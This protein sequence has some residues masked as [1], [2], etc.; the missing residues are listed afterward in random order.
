[1]A[2]HVRVFEMFRGG[3]GKPCPYKGA[4]YTNKVFLLMQIVRLAEW[5]SRCLNWPLFA[6]RALSDAAQQWQLAHA[7]PRPPLEWGGL[8]GQTLQAFQYVGVVEIEGFRVEVFPKLDA[9]LLGGAP[10]DAELADST[11]R[12]LLPMLEAANFGGWVEVGRAQ[13][14]EA[15]LAFSDVWAYLLGKHLAPELRQGLVRAYRHECDDLLGVRGK[16]A[17]SRQV[18]AL[19]GRMDKVACEWDEFS[20]DTP[21]NRL[22]KCACRV[23]IGRTSHPVARGALSDCL[24][25]LDEV[26]DVRVGVALRECER[27]IWPRAALR[28]EAAFRLAELLLREL[29]PDLDGASGQSWSFL[30][31]M[32]AVFEGFC[33][34]ALEAR[35][36]CAVETQ[37][38]LPTLL[39]R[40]NTMPQLADFVWTRG[41]RWIG[42]AKWK[43]LDQKRVAIED[44]RQI[45][46][47]AD[48][49]QEAESLI[50]KPRL[51]ILYP[52]LEVATPPKA[53]ETWNRTTLHL[54]PVRVKGIEA[55][56][57][58]IGVG[59]LEPGSY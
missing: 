25:S 31:D 3:H 58:A 18:G 46:I 27:L 19:F 53:F 54:W 42:D 49:L 17:V 20:P 44:V 21:L 52:T 10:V 40:P 50:H 35:F 57:E 5:Q 4:I 56:E 39:R 8:D 47:Y 33:A 14:G 13:L 59:S 41:G 9:A 51:A 16:I 24:F 11:M 36:G 2:C 30:V 29:S 7:L 15:A 6:R 38:K 1:M 22:L 45:T 32:N 28:F 23:L 55:L 43:L 37:K 12:A 48:L 26:T 34:A